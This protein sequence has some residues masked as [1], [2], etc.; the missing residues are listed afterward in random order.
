MKNQASVLLTQPISAWWNWANFFKNGRV[1]VGINEL[2]TPRLAK[3]VFGLKPVIQK[4]VFHMRKQI[5]IQLFL[6]SK[7][8]LTNIT[9]H[10][11]FFLWDALPISFSSML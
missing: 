5:E 11:V 9:W 2:P 6:A 7:Y 3:I 4:P 1:A 8:K 10:W